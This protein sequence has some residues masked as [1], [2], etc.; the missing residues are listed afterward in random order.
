MKTRLMLLAAVVASLAAPL[1]AAQAPARLGDKQV[2]SLIADATDAYDRF[3]DKMNP[4]MRTAILKGA[5]YQIDVKMYLKELEELG[6]EARNRYNPPTSGAAPE[7]TSYLKRLKAF[8]NGLAIRPGMSGA[9][10]YWEDAKP[11]FGRLATAY[12][13]D[14]VTDPTAWSGKRIS[15]GEVANAAAEVKRLAGTLAKGVDTALKADTT[16]DKAARQALVGQVKQLEVSASDFGS[17]FKS[18]RD[19]VP[20]LAR[21]SGM[22]E[23]VGGAIPAGALAG[24]AGATFETIKARMA[25]L[26]GAF[27]K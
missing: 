5:D 21:L 18:G 1:A 24:P 20:A 7:V 11:V 25:T 3:V 13:I 17:E 8:D 26:T 22:F 6:K 19:P 27:G 14:W 4:Q 12:G 23:K 16:V 9:D 10:K 2:K 15:D